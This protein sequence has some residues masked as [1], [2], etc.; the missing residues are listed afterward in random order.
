MSASDADS[1]Q[2]VTLE[3]I[4]V[5]HITVDGPMRTR[6]ITWEDPVISAEQGFTMTPME[7]MLLYAAGEEPQAPLAL[8]LDMALTEFGDGHAVI[9]LHPGEFHYD[10]TGAVQCGVIA[11]LLDAAMGAVIQ[12]RLPA[13][14]GMATLEVNINM[15]RPITKETGAVRA[16]GRI[17]HLGGRVASAEAQVVDHAGILHAHGTGTFFV[18]RQ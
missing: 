11:A 2:P 9:T 10:L 4:S 3:A 15:I 8:A 16:N 1:L 6:T 18:I 7:R 17:V 13:K 5:S 14:V 12:T